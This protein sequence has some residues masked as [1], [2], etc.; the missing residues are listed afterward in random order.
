VAPDGDSPIDDTT[1]VDFAVVVVLVVLGVDDVVVP[2]G[3]TRPDWGRVISPIGLMIVG[4]T[5]ALRGT[6]MIPA[7]PAAMSARHAAVHQNMEARPLVDDVTTLNVVEPDSKSLSPYA[8]RRRRRMSPN[9][10]KPK[11][12]SRMLKMS[13]P[14]LSEEV[15]APPSPVPGAPEGIVAGGTCGGV[16]GGP[17]LMV[18]VDVIGGIVVDVV[19]VVDVEEVVDVVDDPGGVV[20]MDVDVTGIDDVVDVVELEVVVDPGNVDPVV[21]IVVDVVDVVEVV[22]DGDVVEVPIGDVVDV[23]ACELTVKGSQAPVEP[24]NEAVPLPV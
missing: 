20:G 7:T 10:A 13:T 21:G 11:K 9:P 12:R 15:A 6:K 2:A 23:V 17:L 14:P 3:I 5:G 8:W 4:P 19:E 18:V 1:V 22:D 16:V 24:G